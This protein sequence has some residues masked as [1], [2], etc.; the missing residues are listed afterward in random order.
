MKT[1]R[2]IMSHELVYLREGDRPS[3]V[4]RPILELG[5]TAVP[6]L[7]DDH[8]PV[9]VVSLRDLLE[10][11]ADARRTTQPATAVLDTEPIESGA[12]ALAESGR[13]HLVVIDAAGKAVGMVSAIDFVRELVGLPHKHPDALSRV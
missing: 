10:G 1:V 2:D 4:R 5:I 12:R 6:V 7:D 11:D 8:R 13:H 9:G 3:L